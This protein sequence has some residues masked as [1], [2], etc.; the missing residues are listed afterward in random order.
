MIKMKEKLN[1]SEGAMESQD[2]HHYWIIER[3][4]G[5]VS[6]GLCRFCGAR[7][8]FVNYLRD[9]VQM[10]DEEYLEWAEGRS[11]GRKERKSGEDNFS[12][13]QRKGGDRDAVKAGA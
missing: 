7:R 11:F 4:A 10:D 9:C 12:E 2:C 8:E 3:M 6:R 13:P 1:V 5:P